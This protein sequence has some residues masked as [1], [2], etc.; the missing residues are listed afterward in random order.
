MK[1]LISVFLSLVIL[2]ALIP[3]GVS[4]ATYQVTASSGVNVRKGASTSYGILTT[5]PKGSK[6]NVT[7]TSKKTWYKVKLSSGKTGYISSRY[8]ATP[9]KANAVSKYDGF[10]ESPVG[11][12]VWTSATVNVRAS[13]S[14]SSR[15]IGTISTGKVAK[16][17]DIGRDM[18]K[19]AY[20]DSRGKKKSGWVNKDYLLINLPQVVPSATYDIY[21]CYSSRYPVLKNGKITNIPGISGKNLYGGKKVMTTTKKT[22]KKS[23]WIVPCLYK[24][25]QR[26]S[27]AQ[28]A[29]LRGG[30]SLKIIDT[31]R[32]PERS[33]Q[34]YNY[35]VNSAHAR[36]VNP[37]VDTFLAARTSNHNKG[38]AVDC[39]LINRRTGKEYKM[40]STYNLM[41]PSSYTSNNNGN[42]NRLQRYMRSAGFS[43]LSTEWYHF[44][45]YNQSGASVFTMKYPTSLY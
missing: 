34:T 26:V 24:T 44:T 39:S 29:A 38:I 10:E 40:Q 16:V 11:A 19:L 32:T 20:K 1:K 30:D 37:S 25:A 3:F 31:Y 36:Y 13:N 8:L 22:G 7:D 12:S 9:A 14:T 15:V 17:E 42:A 23:Q 41:T 4:A 43:P 2:L 27:T 18:L 5:L 21:N 35:V 28:Q 33:R 6:V 45:D